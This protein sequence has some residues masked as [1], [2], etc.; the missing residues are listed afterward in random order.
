MKMQHNGLPIKPFFP[1]IPLSDMLSVD[2]NGVVRIL[3]NP[4]LQ[5]VSVA[6]LEGGKKIILQNYILNPV[7]QGV[8]VAHLEGGKK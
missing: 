6:H 4:V 8:S 1:V 7:L 2:V 5:G 3:K